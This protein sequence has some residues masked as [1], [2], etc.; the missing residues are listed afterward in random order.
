MERSDLEVKYLEALRSDS[1][2]KLKK[3]QVG[4]IPSMI[5]G[6]TRLGTIYVCNNSILQ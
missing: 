6:C 1:C 4:G 2:L 3:Q 5:I